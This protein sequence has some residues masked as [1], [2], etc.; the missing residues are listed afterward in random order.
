MYTMNFA[1]PLWHPGVLTSH[2]RSG[3]GTAA[4][5][6]K[7]NVIDYGEC[8]SMFTLPNPLKKPHLDISY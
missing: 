5:Q 4:C 8:L 3:D 6:V 1:Y 2:S 7:S